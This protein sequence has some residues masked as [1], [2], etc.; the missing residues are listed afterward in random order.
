MMKDSKINPA[1]LQECMK[2]N[3]PT[4]RP[5][6]VVFSGPVR[7]TFVNLFRPGKPGDDQKE[8]SYGA[9]LL[10]PLGTDMAVF[11][12]VWHEK[13]REA[14]PKSFDANGVP[15]GLHSPFHDQA[16]K[17]VGAKTYAGYTPGAIYMACSSKFKP[18]V[19][20]LSQNPITD[21]E[22]VYSGVWAYCGLLPYSYSNKKTGIGF[23]LQTVMI[24]ADDQKLSGGG[25]DPTK[26]F[27]GV[28]ITAL[29]D[30]AAKF[31]APGI[32]PAGGHQGAAGGLPVQPLPGADDDI[33]SLL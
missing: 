27:A 4:V 8:G 7:L 5:N 29:S 22:R 3:P 30:I 19:V 23:G 1:M 16:E 32:M 2:K 24:L 12:K 11:S 13:A 21:E 6:G 28:Q 10:F 17:A 14:F 20:D 18:A 31:D 26:D 9:T 25:G 15:H 33:S